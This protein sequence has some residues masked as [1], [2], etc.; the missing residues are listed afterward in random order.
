MDENMLEDLLPEI[1][2]ESSN[3]INCSDLQ[4]LINFCRDNYDNWREMKL[5]YII[6]FSGEKKLNLEVNSFSL[7]RN[8]RNLVLTCDDNNSKILSIFDLERYLDF[9]KLDIDEW[10]SVRVTCDNYYFASGHFI[11]ENNG[12]ISF[13]I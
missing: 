2:D 11:D 10:W 4:N 1:D 12:V 9:L 5:N 8:N 3:S 7:D 6:S 13:V